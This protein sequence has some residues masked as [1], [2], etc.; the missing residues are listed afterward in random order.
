[1]EMEVHVRVGQEHEVSASVYSGACSGRTLLGEVM[2]DWEVHVARTMVAQN[3][4][5]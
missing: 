1:M 5:H 4:N 3:W 2:S